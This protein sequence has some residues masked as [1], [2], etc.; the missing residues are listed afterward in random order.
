[1]WT[2]TE[3]QNHAIEIKCNGNNYNFENLSGL[4]LSEKIKFIARQNGI[5][6]FETIDSTGVSI[7]PEDIEQGE[8]T[9]PI[10]IVRFNV[11]A[12]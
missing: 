8:F 1:M 9:P 11:A 10:T 7:S 5:N 2:A 3:A 6:K 4:A 12:A